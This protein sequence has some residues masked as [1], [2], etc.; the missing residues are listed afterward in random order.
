[1]AEDTSYRPLEHESALVV[2]PVGYPAPDCV[3]PTLQSQPLDLVL[4]R[5]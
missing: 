2:I 3:V 1:M 5:V 4:V